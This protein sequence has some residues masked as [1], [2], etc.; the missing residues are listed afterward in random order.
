MNLKNNMLDRCI[1]FI[2]VISILITT[3]YQTVYG[4]WDGY[5][6]DEDVLTVVDMNIPARIYSAGIGIS[7]DKVKTSDFTA[8]WNNSVS[9]QSILFKDSIPRDWSGYSKIEFWIYSARKMPGAGLTLFVNSDPE[10]ES[11]TSSHQIWFTTEFEGWRLMSI[12]INEMAVS[13]DASWSK[14][15]SVGFHTNWINP[16]RNENL[17]VYIDSIRLINADPRNSMFSKECMES[18]NEIIKNNILFRVNSSNVIDKGVKTKIVTE[19]T[20][21]CVIEENGEYFVPASVFK[22]CMGAAVDEGTVSV[23]KNNTG[24]S[25]FPKVINDIVYVPLIECAE[26]LG[27]KTYSED[28]LIIISDNDIEAIKSD[29]LCYLGVQVM[30]EEFDADDIT[31]EDFE[32]AKKQWKKSLVCDE[33]I[34]LS[35][36]LIKNSISEISKKAKDSINKL[37]KPQY[38]ADSIGNLFGTKALSTTV[39]EN[40]KLYDSIKS[41]A[42]A[43]GTYG[44]DY[45]KNEDLLKDILYCLEWGYNNAYGSNVL[46]GTGYFKGYGGGWFDW[47]VTCPTDIAEILVI[48]EDDM[49]KIYS[50]KEASELI[51][52]YLSPT[53]KNI[54]NLSGLDG[55]NLPLTAYGAIGVYLMVG[56]AQNIFDSRD[57]IQRSMQY[58]ENL[59]FISYNETEKTENGFHKDGSY[60]MHT[61]HAMTG[62]YGAHQIEYIGK[63]VSL[64][65]NTK[66][67]MHSPLTDNFSEWIINGYDPVMYKGGV[68]S[69]VT[70]RSRKTHRYVEKYNGISILTGM[71]DL[72]DSGAINK[73]DLQKVKEI[74]K[75]HIKENSYTN[76]FSL[77]KLKHLVLI[78][79]L[80][81]DDSIEL[82]KHDYSRVFGFM[83]KFI[84]QRDSEGYAVGISASSSRIYNFESLNSENCNGWYQGDGMLYIYNNQDQ[85]D[86]NYWYN[87]NPYRMAGTTVDTQEREPEYIRGG[88]EY[89]SSQDFVGG[90]ETD[91]GYM[92]AAM[93]LESDHNETDYGAQPSDFA[94]YG[95][96]KP[97][98]KSS[99]TAK[100]SWFLFDNEVV[101]LGADIESHEGVNVET[102]IENRKTKKTVSTIAGADV[103]K[104]KI[105]AVEA[106]GMA[107][108]ENNVPENVFDEDLSAVWAAEKDSTLT[109]DLGEVKPVGTM[110]IAFFN[111]K[112]RKI[113]FEL[114]NSKDK[115]NWTP[116]EAYTSDGT[117]N[118]NEFAINSDA[119][120]IRFIGHGA[121]VS[122]WNSIKEIEVYKALD[123]GQTISLSSIQNL[124]T[125]KIKVNS[126]YW[127][128]LFNE[129]QSK[130]NVKYMHLE[131]YGGI[132]FPNAVTLF[133]RR[134]PSSPSFNEF[135]IDHG[136]D[137]KGAEY[138]YVILPNRT[139]EQTSMYAANPDVEILA[140]NS[141]VQ[142]VRDKSAKSTGI[143]FW[144]AGT[145][146][147]I[148]VTKPCII[149]KNEKDDGSFILFISDPTHKVGNMKISINTDCTYVQSDKKSE[150]VCI[151]GVCTFDVN[152]SNTNGK[153][154]KFKFETEEMNNEQGGKE[155]VGNNGTG[156]EHL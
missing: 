14:V 154:L 47:V 25:G 96:Y 128:N 148:T 81:S 85:F 54:K 141:K 2:A 101:A 77:F 39:C 51:N 20:Q 34:D 153:T 76:L 1:S 136:V 64:L 37:N 150:T 139:D 11:G 55:S 75:Y 102:I 9:K 32:I 82:K 7:S 123:N 24:Y 122:T 52:K 97:V 62:A 53:Y 151:D 106:T 10:W 142:A 93:A 46:T 117:D 112:G 109:I 40:G 45:Y 105:T 144:E 120:Y 110:L 100:K 129:P 143:V 23:V 155:D 145:F 57:Y 133:A 124:S 130:D 91:D 125:E 104:L 33:S 80:L 48:I 8:H 36:E 15:V 127:N 138:S 31:I 79:R 134:A 26:K 88:Y 111:G 103:E 41:M 108:E 132:Y 84:Q 22:K 70:G 16:F 94:I 72:I 147:G 116:K 44:S 95:G 92:T 30:Y 114:Q 98:H 19:K 71:L 126:S 42:L 87:V 27:Y 58:V 43:Y 6:S 67:E 149:M 65:G 131:D 90:V 60:V 113:S 119:R 137:P 4:A 146:D 68:M 29:V 156:G 49:K 121:D 28:G 152:F 99:L 118:Y 107:E 59:D 140:N 35:N 83:D 74:V 89:L 66:F 13:R 50:E 61:R 5:V 21:A 86:H 135:W 3:A 73:K 17:D 69:M 63:V 38:K 78:Q 18:G 12:P 115:I 56:D